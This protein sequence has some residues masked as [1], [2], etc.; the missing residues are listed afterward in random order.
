M[1][2]RLS[3]A[4]VCDDIYIGSVYAIYDPVIEKT[5]KLIVKCECETVLEN[6]RIT[7]ITLN[8]KDEP[9]TNDADLVSDIEAAITVM[10]EYR[11]KHNIPMLVHCLAGQN[12]S[13]LVIGMYLHKYNNMNYVEI[14]TLLRKANRTRCVRALWNKDF[15]RILKSYCAKNINAG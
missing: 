1:S 10:A 13:A 7:T 2:D 6:E 8:M 15:Q 5:V 11:T 4:H 12:R 14:V 3:F 9:V